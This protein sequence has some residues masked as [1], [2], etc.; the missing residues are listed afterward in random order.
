M[1][2]IIH[3]CLSFILFSSLAY[4]QDTT[5]KPTP[6]VITAYVDAYYAVYTDSLGTGAYQKYPS[7]SPQ[8]NGFGLNTAVLTAQYDAEKIRGIVSL[9]YGD[10]A[11]SAWSPTYNNL[12]EVHAGVRLSKKLW[13]DAGF[14]RTHFGTEGLLPK[15]NITSSVSINTFMEPYFE[16]GF[17]L[18]YIPNDKLAINLYVLNGYNM[19][20]DNNDKKSL[21][22]LVTYA[23]GDKG[24]IG[25]SN[26]IGDDSP[27]GDTVAHSR[28]HNNLFFNYQIKKLKFQLGGDYC[29]QQNSDT[30]NKNSATMYSGVASFKYQFTNKF[31]VYVRGE[32]FNDPQGFMSGVMTDRKGAQTGLIMNAGTLGFEFKPTDNTYI[33]LEGR[34]I[35]ADEEQLIFYWDGKI[36]N[37]RME[38]MI[39]L[40]VS[41]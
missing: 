3:F 28:F 1:K 25:Y 30:L 21:G 20:E 8:S 41:F 22:L 26:Y 36:T 6:I 34:Q 9:H 17:R 5:K 12:F 29:F 31:A 40:G 39:N 4:S 14:F 32:I 16:S 38:A 33:R 19:F 24:N 37:E 35:R 10:I 15:E 2:K 18:N 13:L 11:K 27:K 23:L 7:V